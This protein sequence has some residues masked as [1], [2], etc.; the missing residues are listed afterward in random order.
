MKT[1]AASNFSKSPLP[2]FFVGIAVVLVLIAANHWLFA[3]YFG[4]SYVQWYLAY[5]ATIGIASAF[6]S[7]I[8]GTLD[9]HPGLISAHPF[10]YIST[11][12]RLVGVSVYA[13]GTNIRGNIAKTA[14][15]PVLDQIVGG[16]LALILGVVFAL[17]VLVIVPLQYFVFL[18]CGAPG[19]LVLRSDRRPIAQVADR[20][21]EVDEIDQDREIPAGWH[22]V[23]FSGKP[24]TLTNLFVVLLTSA[25]KLT[26]LDKLL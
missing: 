5:A 12:L 10:V 8:W 26:Q 21:W 19:R 20:K 17:G 13:L 1:P 6:I 4:T 25:L 9:K 11:Y 22:D 16:L 2:S 3:T 23:S 15:A 7:T 18:V 24:F 14:P